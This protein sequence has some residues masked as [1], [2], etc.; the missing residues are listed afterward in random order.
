MR[1]PAFWWR[2]QPEFRARMTAALLAPVAA[3]YGGVT[4]RRMARQGA[5]V[6][7]PVICIGNFVAG[8][9]G[10]TPVAL[11]LAAY[12][13]QRGAAP[14]FVSRGYGGTFSGLA[15]ATRIDLNVHGA[16]QAG[17]EPLLLAATAPTYVARDRIAGARMALADGAGIIILDDGLQNPALHKDLALAVVDGAVGVGNGRVIPAGPLRAS[18]AAQWPAVHAVVIIGEGAAGDAIAA[19][20]MRQGKPALRARLAPDPVIAAQLAGRRVLALAGIGRPAKFAATL[21]EIGAEVTDLAA[22]GDHHPYSAGE[23]EPL[24]ARAERDE[25][26]LVTTA[27]DAAR[28]AG[29]E[30][31]AP[32]LARMTV[33]PVTLQFADTAALEG[34]LAQALGRHGS[35]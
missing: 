14:A 4:A 18:L 35:A 20:A 23:L 30:N 24:V 7:A 2:A 32:L 21:T 28:M 11:A 10:K 3:I 25:M 16:A 22:F 26:T 13:Q 29:A 27:K 31:L 34:V 9:A 5:R 6:G 8:G 33:L 1:A 15:G 19:A 17:D 12:L